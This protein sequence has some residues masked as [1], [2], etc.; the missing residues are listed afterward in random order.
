MAGRTARRARAASSASAAAHCPLERR[1]CSDCVRSPASWG[2]PV[3]AILAVIAAAPA[4][5]APDW[6]KHH[7]VSSKYSSDRYLTGFGVASGDDAV[8]EAKQQAAAD[9]AR[10]ISVRI[11]S[12]VSDVSQ[13]QDGDYSY[14]L[15]AVTRST[16]DIRLSNLSYEG[17]YKKW[18]R[19]YVLAWIE[20]SA[21]AS[22]RSGE[23]DRA[24][25]DLR[26]C[27]GAAK[28]EKEAGRRPSA[29]STY[30]S[31]RRPIA[32]ALQHDAVVSVLSGGRREPRTFEELVSASRLVDG[33]VEAI[34][35]R[36][37]SSL[38]GAADAM[39][40]QLAQQQVST[41]SRIVVGH[42]NYGSTN[43]SSSF[44]R[45]AGIE[46][47]R[48]L[49]RNAQPAPEQPGSGV[50]PDLALSGVYLQLEGGER[51][52]L[53]V[54]AREVA[55]GRL[56][57]SAETS[58][59]LSALPK[60]LEIK[61]ANFEDAL[62]DQR[63]L[64]EGGL[65]SGKLKL[66]VWTDKGRGGVLYTENEELKLFLRVNQPAWIRLLYVLH[67]GAKVPIDQG[68]YI[69]SSKVN[70]VVEYPGSFEVIAPFGIELLHATAFTEEPT[71]LAT[72]TQEIAG[73]EYEVL[74]DGLE[75]VV[76]T[77][78]LARKNRSEIAEDVVTVTTTPR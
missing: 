77:R 63:I 20:R 7:G 73:V 5:A 44:G 8:T 31:C 34:L 26:A 13:E 64:T 61:P 29:L 57:A 72:R 71:R 22:A 65:V 3:L 76:R 66:E 23:R 12:E 38:E 41:R 43:L 39:A 15:A 19:V 21:A 46:L 40:L 27:L 32:E 62:K 33:E 59:P 6:V 14:K 47:E 42:F 60:Q 78:G 75:A 35:R 25:A 53:S 37:A 55:S 74:S 2:L 18:G 50:E 36:P 58:L 9:L 16:T 67:N 10:K 4:T 56:V 45:Q 48:A 1:V 52:R 30:Q 70:R 51:L 11:E 68:Y 24:I 54:T 69:D 17:P 28:R 49:A